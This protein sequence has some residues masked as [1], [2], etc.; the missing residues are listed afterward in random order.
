MFNILLTKLL[1][2]LTNVVCLQRPNADQCCS[3][4]EIEGMI[5]RVSIWCVLFRLLHTKSITFYPESEDPIR[6][7]CPAKGF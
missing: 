6:L 7:S 4:H 5:Y 1:D 2:I 3:R